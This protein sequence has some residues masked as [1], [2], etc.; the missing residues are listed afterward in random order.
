M[1]AAPLFEKI[2]DMVYTLLGLAGELQAALRFLASGG[3]DQE[4]RISPA[5]G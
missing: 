3:F 4:A 2:A 5:Q 1:Y